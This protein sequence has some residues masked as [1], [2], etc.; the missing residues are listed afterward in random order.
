[1]L[2][3]PPRAV[4]FLLLFTALAGIFA[5][6]NKKEISLKRGVSFCPVYTAQSTAG[7]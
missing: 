4:R 5:I 3:A 2:G 6:A 7:P 1:M